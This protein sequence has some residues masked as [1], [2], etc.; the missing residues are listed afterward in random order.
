MRDARPSHITH[1]YAISHV[2]AQVGYMQCTQGLVLQPWMHEPLHPERRVDASACLRASMPASM[3]SWGVSKSGS[4]AASDTTSTPLS[5][6]ELARSDSSMVF[7]GRTEATQAF[8][9]VSKPV[10]L[11]LGSAAHLLCIAACH[12]HIISI[13]RARN[14][15]EGVSRH[16]AQVGCSQPLEMPECP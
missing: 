3:I 1:A 15:R 14:D 7:E 6:R 4:P 10:P 8:R 12:K 13:L 5:F 11:L 16:T 2:S 9:P